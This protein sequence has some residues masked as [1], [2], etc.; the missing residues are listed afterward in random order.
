MFCLLEQGRVLPFMQPFFQEILILHVKEQIGDGRRGREQSCE[1]APSIRKCK[2][3]NHAN[4][5][6]WLLHVHTWKY[7]VRLVSMENNA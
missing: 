3:D 4:A 5:Q 7:E 6:A 1:S 2:D